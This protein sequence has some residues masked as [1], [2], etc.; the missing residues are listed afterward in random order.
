LLCKRLLPQFGQMKN[1]RTTFLCLLALVPVFGWAQSTYYPPNT[2]AW[3][4]IDPQELGWCE[5][6]IDSLYSFLEST[7]TK[8]F[9]VLKNGKIVLEKYFGTFTQDSLWYWASAGKTLTAL[10]TGI[11]QEENH[12][13]IEQPVA[14]FLGASWTECSLEEEQSITIRHQLT[15]T[16]GLDDAVADDDCTLPECLQCIAAPGTRWAYHNAP[17]TLLSSVI[18]E[19]IDGSFS[20]YFNNSIR[21]P[22]GMDGLWLMSDFNNVYF[23]RTRSAAR[24]GWCILNKTAW[25]SDTLLHDQEYFH[26]MTTSSQNINPAYGYLWWLNGTDSYMLPELQFSFDGYALPDAPADLIA[27][28]GKNGQIINVVPSDSLVVVRFGNLPTAGIF[29]PNLY[30]NDIWQY[31]NNLVCTSLNESANQKPIQNVVVL[32]GESLMWQDLRPSDAVQVFSMTGKVIPNNRSGNEIRWD[33]VPGWY[34]VKA[35]TSVRRVVVIP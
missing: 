32:S 27:A 28:L 25:N 24:F 12:L 3:S 17:Y 5:E 30:N 33:G 13:S 16:S 31:M 7:N 2:G 19:A 6:R 1:I 35:G 26:A 22:I 4:T 23:S 10:L 21:N 9:M 34:I 11:A 14:D 8:S 18:A 29:V 15:M 20:Q